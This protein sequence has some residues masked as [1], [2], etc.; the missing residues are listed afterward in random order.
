LTPAV[1]PQKQR[2]N[3]LVHAVL[4]QDRLDRLTAP[5]AELTIFESLCID[6]IWISPELTVKRSP[7]RSVFAHQSQNLQG[8]FGDDRFFGFFFKSLLMLRS[9]FIEDVRN[10]LECP[11]C[12]AQMRIIVLIQDAQ[13]ISEV[14]KAK[15]SPTLEH[16]PQCRSSSA[17]QR[18]SMSGAGLAACAALTLAISTAPGAR[19]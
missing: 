6:Q 2:P 15:I 4:V 14:L 11:K 13:A 18:L 10:P 3:L 19:R 7:N 5:S 12:K 16:L 17:L 9:G 8:R 1:L